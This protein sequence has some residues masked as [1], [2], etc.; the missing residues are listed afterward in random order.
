MYVIFAILIFS[1]LITVHELGH[2][3]T[4][5]VCGVQVN[6]FSIFMGPKLFQRVKGETTYT[7]RC[8][9][10][11]G[12]CAMEGEDEDS[13]NP[14]AFTWAKPWKRALILIS[15]AAMNY[16][17]GL[18]IVFAVY[19]SATCFSTTEITGFF[20]GCPYESEDGLQAG[21]TLYAVDGHRIHLVGEVTLFL[22]SS[23]KSTHNV[24][25]LRDG[26]KVVLKDYPLVPVAYETENGTEMKYGFYFGNTI[27]ATFGNKMK[28]A[29]NQGIYFTRMVW[30]SL[31]SLLHGD[32]KVSDMSGPVGIVA[33]VSEV[34][35]SAAS[36]RDGVLDVLYIFAF[37]AV[38]LA[39]V[40]MLPIPA[41]DGGRVF[42]LLVTWG[43]E[44]ITR[45][46]L[47]P[48]YEGYIHAAGM[49][50]L[51]ALMAFIMFQD[52]VKLFR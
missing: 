38:N 47:N 30:Y 32:A 29:W 7:L 27:P 44:S 20:E 24:T 43:I 19:S 8:I 17:V 49:A 50:L 48:K 22:S 11:G 1:I 42:F 36:V 25:L 35:E 46:R 6:E 28:N 41:L 37:I 5:K 3:I 45:K 52:I 34:G 14:R 2:F 21:D 23:D 18:L 9:P 4:A 13:D 39:V 31:A 12:F 26:K 51:L 40:N 33:T 15:G 16:L 10:I